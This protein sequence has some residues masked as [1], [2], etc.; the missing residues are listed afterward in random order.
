MSEILLAGASGLIG[1]KL[2][3]KLKQKNYK[4]VLL[5][6]QKSKHSA[7][8]I[9]YWNPEKGIFP[10]L[11]LSRFSACFNF[12]GAGIFDAAIT[13]N[14]KRILLNSRILPINFLL[15]NFEKQNVTLP[16][17]ISASA[18][19]YYPNICLNELNENSTVGDGFISH[20]VN[21]WEQNAALFNLKAE[22]LSTVRIG[23][24][25]SADGG[26]LKKLLLP[27]KYHVAAIPGSGKQIISWIHI[28]DLCDLFIHIMENKLEGV[29]NAT[30]PNP[31]TLDNLTGKI[32]LII[33][34]PVW[35]PNIPVFALR[36]IFGSERAELLLCS[37]IISSKKIRD[38]GFNFKYTDSEAAL[39]N[40]LK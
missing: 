17:F 37:Q 34:K 4:I 39:K 16:H 23:I 9:L 30:A 10:D 11:D 18:S 28:D 12:C 20:L 3:K 27:F 38:T 5:S 25:L 13:E 22:K 7:P 24:V 15:N 8:E 14:R 21:T 2:I 1:S 26:F 40:L 32:G 36:L 31:D 29:F 33:D 19:G 35:L 6:T